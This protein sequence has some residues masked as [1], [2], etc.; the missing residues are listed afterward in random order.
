VSIVTRSAAETRALGQSLA[1]LLDVGDVVLL[2]GDLGAGK[3]TFVKGIAAG[4]GVDDEV[5]S[6]TFTLARTYDDG[7][8]PLVHVDVYRLEREHEVRDLGLE[9]LAEDG[10]LVVEWGDV[11][12]TVLGGDHLDVR[13]ALGAGDDERVI[14][15]GAVGA[16][17][18][19]REA[20]LAAL[21]T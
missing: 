8:L 4:L 13:L 17:W 5:V 20:A 11:V 1:A 2:A 6:P 14:T 9:E 7:R 15:V 12:T 10:V 18:R 3:T 19:A 16:S 21:G